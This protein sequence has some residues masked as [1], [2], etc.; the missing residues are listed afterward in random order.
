MC[1]IQN[2][3][4]ILSLE[5]LLVTLYCCSADGWNYYFHTRGQGGRL[6]QDNRLIIFGV[7]GQ[8][9]PWFGPHGAF[10]Q[11]E[12]STHVEH[13]HFLAQ[14]SVHAGP[15]IHAGQGSTST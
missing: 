14:E 9:A 12:H 11:T 5:G 10:K 7:N 15:S 1:K 8:T 2:K 13:R 4:R 6:S 3:K